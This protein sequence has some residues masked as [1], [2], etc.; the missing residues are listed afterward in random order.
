[1]DR[2]A[3]DGLDDHVAH[4]LEVETTLHRAGVALGQL[5][6]VGAAEEVRGVQQ[7]HVQRVALDPLAAVEKTPERAD[8]FAHVDA[9]GVLHRQ[10]SRHLIGDRTDATDSRGDVGR[11]AEVT[12]PEQ[13]FEVARRFKDLEGD[14]GDESVVHAHAQ[15]ALALDARE[16]FGADG[17]DG[18]RTMTHD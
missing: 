15:R 13:R 3:P 10:T 17:A 6:R 16:T 8:P 5:D 18:F 4:A 14:V 1:M 2:P 11:L 12:T 7:V 9:A